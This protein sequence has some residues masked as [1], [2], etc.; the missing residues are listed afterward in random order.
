MKRFCLAQHYSSEGKKTLT[1]RPKV[2]LQLQ[3]LGNA[4]EAEMPR[5]TRSNLGSV[6][7]GIDYVFSRRR[8]R[9]WEDFGAEPLG[10]ACVLA[11]LGGLPADFIN[12]SLQWGIAESLNW[13]VEARTPD[14]GWGHSGE[15]DAETTSWALVALRRNRRATPGAAIQLL[16]RCRRPDGGF[17]LRPAGGPG[18][19]EATALAIQAMGFID[20]GAETF[21]LTC[22]QSDGPRM[23]SPLS[24]CLAILE[25]DQGVASPSL[26]NQAC[27]LVARFA[28]ETAMEQALLL[29]CLTR[30]R[31]NRAWTQAASLRATQQ[32][33][34]SW[35]GPSMAPVGSDNE[36]II[37][38]VTAVSALVL[39]ESQ[40]GL[41]FGSD[42]PH[43]RRLYES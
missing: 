29:H 2:D 31:L 27:Q 26:V 12:R 40:P 18:D 23:A 19:P 6:Q 41:Y 9:H 15:D 24:I 21:L 38:T 20:E 39:G 25:W 8:G 43:P 33:D 28:A 10:T 16:H 7:A 36:N 35:P 32:I 1:K 5:A 17:A 37:P 13:L 3:A 14:G 11:R 4:T 42:L 30:L 22:L 34:G